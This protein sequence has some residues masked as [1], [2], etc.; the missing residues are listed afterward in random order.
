MRNLINL[1]GNFTKKLVKEK[2]LEKRTLDL[3]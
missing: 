2:Q 1:A 3:I